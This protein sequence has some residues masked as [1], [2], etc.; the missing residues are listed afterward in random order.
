MYQK[1]CAAP[2]EESIE[3]W[4]LIRRYDFEVG[5]WV[6]MG[7]ALDDRKVRTTNGDQS[8]ATA[9]SLV[10]SFSTFLCPNTVKVLHKVAVLRASACTKT[11]N[12]SLVT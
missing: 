7:A 3:T 5:D 4:E 12:C 11:R 9:H 2:W 10:G 6:L 1:I 8:I